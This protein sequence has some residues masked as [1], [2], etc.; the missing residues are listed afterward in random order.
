MKQRPHDWAYLLC[1]S[2]TFQDITHQVS[3]CHTLYTPCFLANNILFLIS[4]KPLSNPSNCF[5]FIDSRKE[6][7]ITF[8]RLGKY[9]DVT[10]IRHIYT[11]HGNTALVILTTTDLRL[12]TVM[13][14][15][16]A[17]CFYAKGDNMLPTQFVFTFFS[18]ASQINSF[19]SHY[20]V[21]NTVTTCFL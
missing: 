15:I 2:V 21:C 16:Y 3:N 6:K 17:T 11:C 1:A 8:P 19:Y 14:L 4:Y 10:R 13:F 9:S 18:Y 20:V 7:I 12:Q 5:T